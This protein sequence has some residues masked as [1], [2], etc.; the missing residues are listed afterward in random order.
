DALRAS[1]PSGWVV[2]TQMPLA[3]DDES[4]PEPDVAVVAGRRED[5][6]DAHPGR[7]A[8][9]IEVAES[10]LE[11]DREYKGSLYAHATV[12][13]YW[14]VNIVERVVEVYRDPGP[15]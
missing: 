5:Y 13:E 4:A 1:L 11:I 7:P 12:D 2:R 9:V 3:L 14:I 6:R 15:D 8:L 10:S